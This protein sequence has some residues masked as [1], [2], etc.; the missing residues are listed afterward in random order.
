MPIREIVVLVEHRLP[1]TTRNHGAPAASVET[2]S[3]HREG[4]GLVS[5][6]TADWP[7]DGTKRCEKQPGSDQRPRREPIP[8]QREN[9][10]HQR[11]RRMSTPR[12]SQSLDS[13]PITSNL[14]HG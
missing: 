13:N 12:T 7:G 1:I 6:K 4:D 3:G 2:A 14:I 10:R 9:Q 5:A 11:D 8:C